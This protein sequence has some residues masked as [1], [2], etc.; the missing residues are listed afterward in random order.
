M[1]NFIDTEIAAIIRDIEP[2]TKIFI[3]ADHGFGFIGQDFL[4]VDPQDL[5]ESDDCSYL[6]CLLKVPFDQARL[7]L[8]TR[9]NCLQFTP[10]ELHYPQREDGIK[11]GQEVHKR[12]ESVIFPKMGYSFSRQGS[13]F[14]PKVYGHG[15]IS[16]Q[17]MLIPMVVLKAKKREEGL[18]SL[19][20]I[21]GPEEIL[22]GEEGTFV[23][24]MHTR[25]RRRGMQGDLR[26]EIEARY[27]NGEYEA[28][29]LPQRTLYVSQDEVEVAYRFQPTTESAT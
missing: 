11:H 5:N 26:V 2:E 9:N 3:V 24:H 21:I 4:Y 25:G 17:E 6:N 13:P 27:S 14:R 22:E 12:Y 15:G 19:T 10:K 1:K 20:P 29:E 16:L 23:L 18:L 8:K 7:P 28:V